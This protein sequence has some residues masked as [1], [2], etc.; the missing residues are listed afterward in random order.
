MAD[1][2]EKRFAPRAPADGKVEVEYILPGPKPKDISSSGIYLYEERPFQRGQSIELKLRLANGRE[3]RVRGMVRRVDPGVGMGIE[4]INLTAH[5][6]KMLRDF[7][8]QLKPGSSI[9]VN[10]DY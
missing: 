2:Q 7:V 5:D 9:S 8:E 4:F 3:F 10:D 6:R 1:K